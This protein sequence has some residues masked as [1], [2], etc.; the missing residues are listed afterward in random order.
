MLSLLDK[1]LYDNPKQC[2]HCILSNNEYVALLKYTI[3][4]NIDLSMFPTVWAVL[5]ILLDTQ[6]GN[7][8]Y[9]Q[10]LQEE[11]NGYYKSKSRK[12]IEK[13]EKKSIEIQNCMHDSV[14]HNFDRVSDYNDNGSTPPQGQQDEQSEA[15]NSAENAIE[16]D[17]VDILTGYPSW[18]TDTN[19]ICDNNEVICNRNRKEIQD[20]LYEDTPGKTEDNKPY[21]DLENIDAY[22]RDK[23]LIT[24][25]LSDRLGLGKNSLP[26]SQQVR[27][28]TMHTDQMRDIPD[29]LRWMSL[30]EETESTSYEGTDRNRN[31]ISQVDGTMDSRD[32]FNQSLGSIDLT[33]SPVRLT[34]TQRETAKLNED[35]SDDDIDEMIE[36]N[37]DIAR[38]I[39][40]KDMNEQRKRAKI[41]KSNKVRTTKIYALNIE[42]KRILKQRRE[43]VLQN[44]KDRKIGKANAPVA[45][46]A[47][48][49]TNRASKDTQ[50][51]IMTDNAITGVDNTDNAIIGDDNTDNAA[52][53][54]DNTNNAI[55]GNSNTDNAITGEASTVHIP[56]PPLSSGKAKHPRQIKTSSKHT[57]AIAE[58]SIGDPLPDGQATVKAS[59]HTLD[60]GDV[61][62]YEFLIQGAP[63]PPDLEGIEEDQLLE[64]QQNIQDK[65]KQRD[66]ERQRNITKR[67]K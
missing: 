23:A 48:T 10:L 47:S 24:Q 18:S 38:K 58:P 61:G 25:S 28:A 6:D 12:Y 53:G 55:I 37:K 51:I 44:A 22:N 34:N 32:S 2:T 29:H 27:V 30:G 62:M 17:A 66:E 15:V 45:L 19:D 50:N 43:K 33:E 4:L 36:F 5:S 1:Y 57:T 67:M 26:G 8:E 21:I 16:H 59:G 56:L 41:V 13:F 20:E 46:Q 9:V 40:R 14:T 35:T 7:L 11:Y 39:Y 52:I 63:N 49:R 54:N 60:L 42:R 31:I 65:L 3:C 64:I